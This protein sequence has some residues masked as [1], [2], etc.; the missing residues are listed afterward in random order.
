MTVPRRAI[1]W[2]LSDVRADRT[3]AARSTSRSAEVRRPHEAGRAKATSHGRLVPATR[4]SAHAGLL[5]VRL[6]ACQGCPPMQMRMLFG[7]RGVLAAEPLHFRWMAGPALPIPFP[8]DGLLFGVDPETDG[9]ERRVRK[10]ALRG[11]PADQT[12]RRPHT[13]SQPRGTLPRTVAPPPHTHRHGAG[14]APCLAARSLHGRSRARYRQPHIS[15]SRTYTAS[16]SRLNRS[17]LKSNSSHAAHIMGRSSGVV[18]AITKDTQNQAV[19]PN[20]GTCKAWTCAI[21]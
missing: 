20:I 11:R 21:G 8:P 19:R 13:N 10:V 1:A 17:L 3:L 4:H 2:L 15:R 16:S 5:L 9:R 12:D 18:N 7:Q 14:H 6:Q